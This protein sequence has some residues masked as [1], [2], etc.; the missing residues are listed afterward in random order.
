MKATFLLLV[1]AAACTT[2]K[3][4]QGV[5][6]EKC[7]IKPDAGIYSFATDVSIETAKDSA[8]S[9]FQLEYAPPE[10]L[11]NDL[12]VQLYGACATDDKSFTAYVGVKKNTLLTAR[13]DLLSSSKNLQ[14][15]QAN[16]S[17]FEYLRELVNAKSKLS[18]WNRLSKFLERSKLNI[19]QINEDLLATK[20]KYMAGNIKTAI[21]FE[22]E[23]S[24]LLTASVKRSITTMGLTLLHDPDEAE[25]LIS[26][27]LVKESLPAVGKFRYARVSA[28]FN[29]TNESKHISTATV[30]SKG[31]GLD[32]AQAENS[33]IK[34]LAK[35]IEARLGNAILMGGQ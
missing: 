5:E 22:D 9:K 6:L 4:Y 7:P 13:D 33:A 32:E 35:D 21:E 27:K 16:I 30:E 25:L 1:L 31:G 11:K 23:T 28:V 26:V 3:Y 10:N 24:T 34:S 8:F 12:N 29:I 17:D 19:P 15:N 2:P 14:E 18:K 20:I